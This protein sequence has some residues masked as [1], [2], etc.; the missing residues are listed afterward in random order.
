[1]D[2]RWI[3]AHNA[4]AAVHAVGMKYSLVGGGICQ[5]PRRH[6]VKSHLTSGKPADPITY[7]KFPLP[8]LIVSGRKTKGESWFLIFAGKK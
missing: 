5:S 2:E 6:D 8:L 7:R 3:V 1:M 4:L